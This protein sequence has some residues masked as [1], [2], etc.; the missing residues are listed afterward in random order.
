MSEFKPL[1]DNVRDRLKA[2]QKRLTEIR[3]AYDRARESFHWQGQ[4]A[5]DRL[6]T[7]KSVVCASDTM[8]DSAVVIDLGSMLNGKPSERPPVSE[9]AKRP[10][11]IKAGGFDS[12]NNIDVLAA[13]RTILRQASMSGD[14]VRDEADSLSQKI[15]CV[16]W[17]EGTE[18]KLK[19]EK[20]KSMFSGLE[21]IAA[22]TFL[23]AA[24]G[25][26]FTPDWNGSAKLHAISAAVGA[27]IGLAGSTAYSINKVI[28]MLKSQ[29][30]ARAEME[31][32]REDVLGMD[33]DACCSR[34]EGELKDVQ[35]NSTAK[36]E[37]M[38]AECLSGVDELIQALRGKI[39]WDGTFPGRTDE[40]LHNARVNL[41]SYDYRNKVKSLS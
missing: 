31:S 25:F 28:N 3:F 34:L 2:T 36:L 16:L 22:A 5:I 20:R 18:G 37:A 11:S 19:A 21:A 4:D 6:D 35:A 24:C 17:Q 14:G 8:I 26:A 10:L 38:I 27:A 23:G 39:K 33:L 9:T 13:R 32:L 12:T 1:P 29:K 41:Q 30:K 40:D 15:E 7:A